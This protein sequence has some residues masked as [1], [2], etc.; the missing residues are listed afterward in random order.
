MASEVVVREIVE[1][2]DD[3]SPEIKERII[4]IATRRT[5]ELALGSFDAIYVY[6]GYLIDRFRE[7]YARVLSLDSPITPYSD[8]T[9]QD[10]IGVEDNYFEEAEGLSAKERLSA[11]VAFS[12]LQAYTDKQY[13]Y[14]LHHRSADDTLTLD[15]SPEDIVSNAPTDTSKIG[16]ITA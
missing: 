8:L 2:Y 7:P 16:R 10:T 4:R 13:A 5:S 15:V 9:F 12:T 11:N 1:T 6:V 3:L 14:L